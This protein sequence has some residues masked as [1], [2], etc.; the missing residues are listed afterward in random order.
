M[1]YTPHDN[2]T[3]IFM[4]ER[5]DPRGYFDV[6]EDSCT[7][8]RELRIRD[9]ANTCLRLA[10]GPRWELR[11]SGFGNTL[12][13][14]CV[15]VKLLVAAAAEE[16]E[17][18]EPEVPEPETPEPETPEPETPEPETPEPETPEPEVPEPEVP[19]KW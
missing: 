3:K 6:Y 10:S 13:Q 8:E 5:G 9:G 19:A 7:L 14:D 11:W 15:N 18:P 1:K 12:S 16:P 2:T 17:V 4:T